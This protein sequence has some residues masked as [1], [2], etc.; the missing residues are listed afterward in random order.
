MG[1][2]MWISRLE[3]VVASRQVGYPNS[4]WEFWLR[5]IRSFCLFCTRGMIPK[6]AVCL[7]HAT[8]HARSGLG[9]K[10]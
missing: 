6:E 7:D 10:G 1:M 8:G 5:G 4:R 3:V 9:C 2:W